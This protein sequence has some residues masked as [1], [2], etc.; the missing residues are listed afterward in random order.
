AEPN[1]SDVLRQDIGICAQS[2]YGA[3]AVG[4]VD[5]HRAARPDSMGMEENHDLADDF[6]FGPRRLDPPTPFR[7]DTFD[8]LQPGGVVVDNI[9]NPLAEFSHQLAGV[10][11]AN[12][13]NHS[14]G[15][16]FFNPFAR[17]RWCAPKQLGPELQP[18]LTILRPAALGG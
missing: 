9:K 4:F 1:A 6:L 3:F 13:L 15:Q 2:F 11:R 17:G 10:R 16:V 18:K 12:P 14:A 7:A 8:F 5:P